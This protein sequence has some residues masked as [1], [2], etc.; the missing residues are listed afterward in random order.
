MGFLNHSTNNVIIDAV[1]TEKGR[2]LLSNNDNSFSISR[3]RLG[4][5]EVDYSI[6]KK[7][8]LIIGKEK[9]EKNTP[10]FEAVTDEDLALK[11]PVRTF[12]ANNT[13][14]IYAFPFLKLRS[15]QDTSVTIT[16]NS[17]SS[18][19]KNAKISFKTFLNQDQDFTITE[20][21]LV[22]S[23]FIV[24]M[25]SKLI[26]I[27]ELEPDDI[28][29]DIAYY[30]IPAQELNSEAEFDN[31]RFGQIIVTAIGKTTN[32]SYKYYATSSNSSEIKTQ[33]EIIGN[34]SKSSLIFPVTITSNSIE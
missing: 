12:V 29:D 24:K 14:S 22:D 13:K 18:L 32:D 27:N 7:Y 31:Q 2:E 30:V 23:E 5:D 8:G 25:F 26:K 3:F 4:D 21:G 33:I 28:R 34:N 1:L 19:G 20:S 15:F 17:S 11:Y 6:L 10:V 16:S 9:I